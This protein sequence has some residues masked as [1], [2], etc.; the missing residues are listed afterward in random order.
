MRSRIRRIEKLESRQLLT[1]YINEVLFA[2]LFGNQD[3]DQ[4][5][6]LRGERNTA[7]DVGTYLLV[8]ESGKSVN[9]DEGKI[10][11]IFDLSGLTFGDNGFLVLQE[12]NSPF[13]S[14]P[15]AHTLKSTS[16]GFSGLPG[17]IFSDVHALSDRL[18][19]IYASN[20]IF[21]I[22]SDVAPALGDDI[23]CIATIRNP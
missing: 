18:D 13:T 3:T 16:L 9:N 12:Q 1:A 21:L 6:E 4:Y 7:L 8:V 17:N 10:E 11:V 2:P 5:V 19:F 22:Q 14:D 20:T 15:L 23:D